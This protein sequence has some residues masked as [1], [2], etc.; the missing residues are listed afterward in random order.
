MNAG[1]AAGDPTAAWAAWSAA[2]ERV[3][4]DA[5]RLAGGPLPLGGALRLGRGRREFYQE[6]LGVF[7]AGKVRPDRSD[8]G[9]ADD[10][11]GYY[12]SLGSCIAVE[13]E[14][15]D[16]HGYFAA[17]LSNGF[18]LARSVVLAHQWEKVLAHGPVGPVTQV[19]FLCLGGLRDFSRLG[20]FFVYPGC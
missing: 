14:V 4:P 5:Y 9:E 16:L 20:G 15:E 3:L 12:R 13:A 2:A 17:F 18:T 1:L 8:P 10:V 11:A 6:R 19:E 7:Q